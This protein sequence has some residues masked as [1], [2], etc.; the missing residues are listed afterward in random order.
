[1]SWVVRLEHALAERGVDRGRRRRI[2]LEL[3]DHLACDPGAE[4]RLGDPEALAGRFA[5]ELAT[6]AT[7]RAAFGAFAALAVV[8]LALVLSPAVSGGGPGLPLLLL[9]V[10]VVALVVAPQAALVAGVLAA[11][12]ALRRRRDP[13]VPA[14]EL[15]LLRARSGVA[16]AAGGAT[17]AGLALAAARDPRPLAVAATVAAAVALILAA[18]ELR[19]SSKVACALPGPAGDLHA[20]LV[21]ARVARAHAWVPGLLAAGAA[22]LAMTALAGAAERSL[23]EGLERGLAEGLLALA[24]FALLGRGLAVRGTGNQ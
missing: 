24:G 17:V 19:E 23:L 12:R 13:A 16:L 8:A 5:D 3:E 2:V 14:A 18:V 1:M 10:A 9:P 7:R 22:A 20:D 4:P 11:L 15:A 6:D 21:P